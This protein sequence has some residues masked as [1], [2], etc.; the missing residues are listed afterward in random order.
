[1]MID[2][3]TV[4]LVGASGGSTA[5]AILAG[6][7]LFT[8]ADEFHRHVAESN[9]GFILDQVERARTLEPGDYKDSICRTIESA[10]ADLCASAPTDAIC[11]DREMHLERA[12][13]R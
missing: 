13:C 8:P 6:V 1:M 5:V 4:K 7:M 12:G 2:P 9:R 11:T 3:A 10:I